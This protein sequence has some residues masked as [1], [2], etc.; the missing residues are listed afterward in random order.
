MILS[1]QAEGELITH[2]F[3]NASSAG[4]GQLLDAHR[5]Y[6]CG[7]VRASPSWVAAT[8]LVISD[9]DEVLDSETQPVQRSRARGFDFDEFDEGIGLWGASGPFGAGWP[10]GFPS[11][12]AHCDLH[13][14]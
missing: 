7:W 3:P 12:L 14:T 5:V 8:G 13:P 2:R 9:V 1:E 10:I 11:L 4:V 6:A